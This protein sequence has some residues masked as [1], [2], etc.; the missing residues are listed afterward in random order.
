MAQTFFFYDLETSGLNPR[1]DRI[2]QFAGQR[3]DMDLNPIG[4][5]YNVLVKLNDDT[6][7]SP[8]AIMVT[9]ITPQSTQADGYT[10][11]EF[12]KLLSEEIFTPDTISVGY[13]NIRFDDEF[14]RHLFWRNFFDP[15]EWC[16]NNGCSRWDLLD[17]VR[18]TRAL[19]P[20]GIKWPVTDEGVATNRLELLT[21]LNGLDHAKAHD[22]L[23]DVL[24]LIDITKLLRT[25]QSKLFGYLF[26]IRDKKSVQKLVN[27]DTKQPFVYTS[28]RYDSDF[29]KTT[30][31]FPL[32][33]APN[34][35]VLVYDLRY[36]P[37]PFVDL[38]EEELAKK[39]FASWEERKA[40]GFVALPIKTLQYNRCP[41][42][43]PIGVLEGSDGWKKIGLSLQTVE[44]HKKTLL[45]HPEF[46]ERLRS[47]SERKRDYK[48]VTDP[49]GQLYDGFVNGPDKLRIETVRNADTKQLADFHPNFDDE[50]LSPLLLHYKARS[51]PMSLSESEATAWEQ[52]R[53]ERLAGQLPSYLKALQRLSTDVG[54]DDEKR[55][56]LEELQLWAEAVVPSDDM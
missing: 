2:M 21:K 15:Y 25:K 11:A 9:G 40:D 35:N 30:V 4:E 48:P 26:D 56:V 6:L 10:E 28:G 42:V 12:A 54:N 31:A 45:A 13:N 14:V 27:L 19:R 41:A 52:W 50:R 36:D 33:S 32:T 49:E 1:E 22:A 37:T 53:G 43:A 55:F 20:E 44:I 34:H 8:D 3:T 29:N 38:S 16:W 7:P 24:A 46:A 23:S 17:V 18:M 47:I 5:P 51:Y 39:V